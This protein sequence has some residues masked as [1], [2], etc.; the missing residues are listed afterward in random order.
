MECVAED[1]AVSTLGMGGD[2]GVLERSPTSPDV[3]LVAVVPE[4]LR[5]SIS[6]EKS[7]STNATSFSMFSRRASCRAKRLDAG[8]FC[9]PSDPPAPGEGAD[10]DMIPLTKSETIEWVDVEW[11]GERSATS[12]GISLSSESHCRLFSPEHAWTSKAD[13]EDIRLKPQHLERTRRAG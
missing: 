8:T 11:Y 3:P 10:I 2:C 1:I 7:S 13:F 12:R 6:N 5:S 4:S 9:I